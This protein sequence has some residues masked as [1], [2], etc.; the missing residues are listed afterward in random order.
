VGK[1]QSLVF[2]VFSRLKVCAA[3]THV[4]IFGVRRHFFM[5]IQEVCKAKRNALG[6]TI[7]DIA[8]ASGIPPS[9]VN[10]FFTHASKAPYIS[11]VGPICA[12][13]GVSLDGF[14]GIGD[15]L[16]ASEETL[17]AEKDGLEHRLENKRKTIGLMDTELCNLWH[18]VKLY[19]WIILGLSLLIIGLFAWCV[20]VDIHC[21]NYGFWRG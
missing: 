1:F 14:Y 19:R 8:E 7:Q 5:T 4:L 6:M 20:W 12:V 11:T 13:L 15:H 18:S 10:N 3:F 17:Q 16:T 21:A 9:T 2:G